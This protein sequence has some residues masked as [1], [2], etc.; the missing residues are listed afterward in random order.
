MSNDGNE[1]SNAKRVT[2][3]ET[4]KEWKANLGKKIHDE[5]GD[6]GDKGDISS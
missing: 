4:T 2:G 6:K 5:G 3:R 1:K